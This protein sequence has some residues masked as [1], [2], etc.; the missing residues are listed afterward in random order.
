MRKT[1][2]ILIL[3]LSFVLVFT[4]SAVAAFAA[5]SEDYG[6]VKV[7]KKS[8][9]ET[10]A[11]NYYYNG[12]VE[13]GTTNVD[14]GTFVFTDYNGL[15]PRTG[16]VKALV[17]RD[18][19]T[20]VAYYTSTTASKLQPYFYIKIGDNPTASGANSMPKNAS[21]YVLDWDMYAPTGNYGAGTGPSIKY[22]FSL[23][24]SSSKIASVSSQFGQI[25]TDKNGDTTING[26]TLD[27]SLQWQH[28]TTIIEVTKGYDT[29]GN[30]LY[31]ADAHLFVDGK[32][33]QS[34][35]GMI[36]GYGYKDFYNTDTSLINLTEI[37]I[38]LVSTYAQ[39]TG[40]ESIALDNFLVRS[41]T[42]YY[43]GAADI[44]AVVEGQKK[45]TEW[46][47]S[48]F[49]ADYDY[50]FGLLA[51]TVT[52]PDGGVS[53]YDNGQDA[54]AN[55]T[56]GS[57]VELHRD[58]ARAT[59]NSSVTVKTNGYEFGFTSELYSAN[60]IE[61]N[62]Y[63]FSRNQN[64][65]LKVYWDMGN[66]NDLFKITSSVLGA[67]PSYP[68]DLAN[69]IV[70]E[71]AEGDVDKTTP[72]SAS[73]LV[74]WSYTK[75][76]AA[77]GVVDD[78]RPV[79]V[80]DIESDTGAWIALYPVFVKSAAK[81]IYSDGSVSFYNEL[82]MAISASTAGSTVQLLC[83]VELTSGITVTK[84][85]TVDLNGYTVILNSNEV[86]NRT[87]LNGTVQGYGTK[88]NLFTIPEG[89]EFELTSTAPG[90]KIFASAYVSNTDDTGKVH[91]TQIM[92]NSVI[93]LSGSGQKES[94]VTING[95][96]LSVYASTLVADWANG[97]KGTVTVNGGSYYRTVADLQGMFGQRSTNRVSYVVNDAFIYSTMGPLFSSN[98]AAGAGYVGGE[99]SFTF[100]NCVLYT[101]GATSEGFA[102]ND[103][104]CSVYIN[105]SVLHTKISSSVGKIYIGEGTVYNAASVAVGENI[106]IADGCQAFAKTTER[107]FSYAPNTFVKDDVN[108]V[109]SSESY[110]LPDAV[111]IDGE[112]DTW[113]AGSNNSLI[114]KWLAPDG[115]TVLASGVGLPGYD[116]TPP[117]IDLSVEWENGDGWRDL[118]VTKWLN[119]DG[120]ETFFVPEGVT[121]E[122][123]FKAVTPSPD[124]A[125]LEYVA[126]PTK[127]VWNIGLGSNI[128]INFYVPKEDGVTINS[129]AV[130][131]TTLTVS[132]ET[133][134]IDEKEYYQATY[135]VAPANAH[136]GYSATVAYTIDG[137]EYTAT[138]APVSALEYV[139]GIVESDEISD[140]QKT[141]LADMMR[142]ISE[143]YKRQNG[144]VPAEY[145]EFVETYESLLTPYEYDEDA[146]Y[147]LSEELELCIEEID[148]AVIDGEAVIL[149][150]WSSDI[151]Y[152]LDSNDSI[153]ITVTQ[154]SGLTPNNGGAIADDAYTI[155]KITDS[156]YL[157]ESFKIT[158]RSS[159][160]IELIG[161]RSASSDYSFES[162]I[163]DLKDA[164]RDSGLA[165]ALYALEKTKNNPPAGEEA[166]V[167][168][169]VSVLPNKEEE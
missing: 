36:S 156:A 28:Y 29:E 107:S 83:D 24:N 4:A 43:E 140:Y 82:G 146:R 80:W 98:S 114:V 106:V 75:E 7:L 162:M 62:I 9:F 18:G 22:V 81:I 23:L 113:I 166:A 66:E 163:L 30:L 61:E 58:V 57:S 101:P 127:I 118:K 37:R 84:N 16:W 133:V 144:S 139:Q 119:P 102:N 79:T 122:Y 69:Y 132:T 91:K 111:I 150:Y 39:K 47:D 15:A 46:G 53:Y 71:Y 42:K 90:A 88:P 169:V 34:K 41:F 8:D 13:V 85:V 112:F 115:V 55:A 70:Y 40:T 68:E 2:R 50:P 93:Y 128:T 126:S 78:I 65:V 152:E 165:E 157:G 87:D 86:V 92:G 117:A 56:A 123:V 38:E 130:G 72:I 45:L 110:V 103:D 26:V 67:T 60:E 32:L 149:I 158:V 74:G 25:M 120:E 145:A 121:G 141:S 151:K 14:G 48:H 143:L 154:N 11:D 116:A 51:A 125:D 147:T 77:S 159:K 168:P 89:V 33:V 31:N 142:Y 99:Y 44:A 100:N 19:N 20:S 136:I 104:E 96:N 109:M 153:R 59:V 76:G 52:A 134:T 167:F 12:D 94:K 73:T 54:F 164:G 105:N 135:T 161:A 63:K 1:T 64:S 10:V 3:V 21:Y 148:V 129:V 155:V 97:L 49:T 6:D 27:S 35:P 137:V 124:D 138:L 160:T 95:Q 17:S 108:K 131:S 5:D